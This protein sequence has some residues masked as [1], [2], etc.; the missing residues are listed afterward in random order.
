MDIRLFLI[1]TLSNFLACRFIDVPSLG[2]SSNVM[3]YAFIP[4]WYIAEILSAFLLFIIINK[5]IENRHIYVRMMTSILLL[6][7]SGLLMYLDVG[8]ILKNT[9]TS[10]VSYFT[11][12]VNITGFAGLLMIGTI[13]RHYKL[14]DIEAHSKCFT[15]VLFALCLLCTVVQYALYDNQY[16]L[17]YG[18]WGQY[19]IWSIPITTITGF[20]LTY[21]LICISYF[22]KRNEIIKRCLS[23]LGANSLDI[24]M[25]HF[26]IAELICMIGGF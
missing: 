14:F 9:Y 13:L 11:I 16:A 2:S 25:L 20:T 15:Y 5:L 23:F 24:L 6:I 4:Y 12:P 8:E 26:G 1:N 10:Q 21:F 7:V 19:G 18:K 17:Q 3:R 22:L